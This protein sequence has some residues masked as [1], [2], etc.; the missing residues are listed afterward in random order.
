MLFFF[1]TS[2]F[3]NFLDPLQTRALGEQ[4][5]AH[6][7]RVLNALQDGTATEIRDANPG[8]ESFVGADLKTRSKF[9]T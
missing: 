4:G 6:P 1:E 3:Q 7:Q 9:T 2:M 5:C 8:F